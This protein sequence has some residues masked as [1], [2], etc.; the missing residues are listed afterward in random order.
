[1][2]GCT[3]WQTSVWRPSTTR[4]G[5]RPLAMAAGGEVV[6]GV[7]AYNEAERSFGSGGHGM[8]VRILT[9]EDDELIATSVVRGLREEG[10]TVEHAADGEAASLALQAG[11]W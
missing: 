2:G 8:G 4:K 7:S 11:R 6:S 5:H 10:F 9:V 1:M 3:S